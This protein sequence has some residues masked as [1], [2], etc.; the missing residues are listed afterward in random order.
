[1][2]AAREAPRR[3]SQLTWAVLRDQSERAERLCVLRDRSYLDAPDPGPRDPRRDLGRFLKIPGLDD[4][5]A[6][7]LLLGFRER[8]VGDRNLA[9]PHP[10]RHRGIGGE[11]PIDPD[12]V[13]ALSYCFG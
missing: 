7:K 13:A 12:E 10:D 11:Q 9:V 4:V 6:A 2:L 5:I 3:G 1:M 8:P